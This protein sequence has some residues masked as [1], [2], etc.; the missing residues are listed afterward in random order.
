M[1][2]FLAHHVEGQLAFLDEDESRHLAKVLRLREGDRIDLVDGDGNLYRAVIELTDQRSTRA[3]IVETIQNHLGRNYHIHI[4]IAPT[5]SSER[6]EWFLEKSTELGVDEITPVLCE[7]SERSKIR[8]DRAERILQAAMKQSGRAR[9]PKLNDMKPLDELV[10]Q[11]KADVRFIAH[12][13]TGPEHYPSTGK[14]KGSS[15]L[16]LIGPE[17][18]FSQDEVRRAIERDFHEISLGEA[19]YR[20]E[21]AGIVACQ[22]IRFLNEGR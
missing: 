5:K 13:G 6:F 4:A 3:R 16:V 19:V 22:T 14:Y 18:D 20:T 8:I 15:W 11:S 10:L 21:T 1:P 7:R 2:V 17:G 12:C 9:L